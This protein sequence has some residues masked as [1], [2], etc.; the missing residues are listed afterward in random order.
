V[1]RPPCLISACLVGVGCRYDAAH[2]ALPSEV[3]E[4]LKARYLLIPVCPEQLGG[5][6]TPRDP[7]QF[8]GGDGEAFWKGKARLL[9]QGGRDFSPALLKGAEEVLKLVDLLDIK[10]AI[11]KEKSPS[12]GVS[13]VYREGKLVRG[14]GVVT[15]ALVAKGVKVLSGDDL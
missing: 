13:F 3:L 1:K 4:G 14:M 6:P 8:H 15:A 9:T 11:L 7:V 10:V 12:C 5:L 2:R